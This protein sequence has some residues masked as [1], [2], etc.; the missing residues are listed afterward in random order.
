MH[1]DER[2]AVALLA[3]TDYGRVATS[4]RALPFLAF[5]RHIVADGRVLLRLPRSW[6]CHRACAGNVVAYGSDNLGSAEP[7]EGLWSV[8]IVGACTA[9][10]PTAA[11]SERFGA[12]PGLV[13]GVPYEPV[14]LRIEPQ[15][16]TVHSAGD[17]PERHF[18]HML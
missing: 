2:L 1:S 13:D 5:A 14:H 7:G 10:E 18:A 3:R 8:Q 17:S 11:E 12:A 6:G 15:F 4:V 16:G 9:Y